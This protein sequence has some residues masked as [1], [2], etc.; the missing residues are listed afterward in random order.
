MLSN[1]DMALDGSGLKRQ[2]FE[3]VKDT[4]SFTRGSITREAEAAIR[5]SLA[6]ANALLG[7]VEPEDPRPTMSKAELAKQEFGEGMYETATSGGTSAGAIATVSNPSVTRNV[8]KPKKNKNGT[9]QNAQD[10]NANLM[11][12]QVIKR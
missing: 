4:N 5:N 1:I 9:A 2:G 7:G 12:G 6:K 11:T 3:L 8:K 10:S